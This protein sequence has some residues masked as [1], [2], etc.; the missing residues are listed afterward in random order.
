MWVCPRRSPS[1]TAPQHVTRRLLLRTSS[2]PFRP[3]AAGQ[4]TSGPV[5]S[6]LTIRPHPARNPHCAPEKRAVYISQQGCGCYLASESGVPQL[7]N[8]LTATWGGRL[9][10]KLLL[11]AHDLSIPAS[12]AWATYA[13]ARAA[14]QHQ[15]LLRS[16]AQAMVSMCCFCSSVA[17]PDT[18]FNSQSTAAA[19][20]W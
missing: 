2:V 17:F 8:P 10:P 20:G 18:A 19:Y 4:A 12:W 9:L 1:A 15:A 16:L 5:S 14:L 3:R 11:P 7:M 6:G 13:D